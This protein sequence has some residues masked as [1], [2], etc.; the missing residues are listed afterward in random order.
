MLRPGDVYFQV[1]G[2]LGVVVCSAFVIR[3]EKDVAAIIFE[4]DIDVEVDI[5]RRLKDMWSDLPDD[6]DML[7]L[8]EFLLL[9]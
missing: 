5:E 7:F 6:W 3:S 4:D 2:R 8:G 9:C 1:D